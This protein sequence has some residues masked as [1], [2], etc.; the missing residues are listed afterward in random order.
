MAMNTPIQGTAA[1]LNKVAMIN[2]STLI[3]KRRLRA[4]M[5]MQVHDELVFEVPLDEKEDV[6]ALVKREMEE[7]I[8]LKVPLKVDI[9]SG[10]NWGEAHG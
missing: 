9:T 8:G 10:S 5:I 7:V 2:I 4:S 6:A 3:A 1:D